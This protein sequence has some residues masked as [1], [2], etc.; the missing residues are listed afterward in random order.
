MIYQSEHLKLRSVMD[1]F[2]GNVN[3][4]MICEDFSEKSGN[5]YTL[6]AVHD[7]EVVKKLLRIIKESEKSMDC[8][9]DM[10]SSGNSF[11]MVFPYVKERRLEDF[12]MVGT[13]PLST[14]E[15]ICMNLLL[16]CM[17]STLPYPL[18]ELVLKQ[19]Q[20]HLLKDNSILLGY[21]IDLSEINE[22]SGEKECTLQCATRIREL[23]AE[24]ITKKNV[25]FQ[26]LM[27]KIPKQSY[28]DF[29]E[30]YKDICLTKTKSGKKS[31]KKSVKAFGERNQSVLF[32]IVLYLSVMMAIAVLIMLLSNIVWG[33]IPFLRIFTNTLKQIG[34]ET[35]G[36]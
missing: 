16:Q 28:H 9:L 2:R 20:M 18:L 27:K 22:N 4:V 1:V 26:L 13:L 7:H 12:Y 19:K 14:C 5:Y 11:C 32:R 23:L 36:K 21:C 6:V 17:A 29:R 34:T 35:L 33:D 30:L 25:S 10:F 15:E 8:C 3:D 31:L 24:K